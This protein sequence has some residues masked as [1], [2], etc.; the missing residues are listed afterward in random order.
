MQVVD[1]GSEV[2]EAVKVDS[3]DSTGMAAVATFR[4]SAW[5]R[6]SLLF[7]CGFINENCASGVV[8]CLVRV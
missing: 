8:L 3:D 6:G 1:F 5:L 2:W 4:S 7:V